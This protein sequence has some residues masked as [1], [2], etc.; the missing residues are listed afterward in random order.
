MQFIMKKYCDKKE[1]GQVKATL[2]LMTVGILINLKIV[3][4]N[5]NSAEY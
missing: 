2:R 1:R 3:Y 4:F 5:E